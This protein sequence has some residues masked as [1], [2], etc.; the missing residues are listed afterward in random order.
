[1]N[2]KSL[3]QKL[4]PYSMRRKVKRYKRKV[5]NWIK[6]GNIEKTTLQDIEALLM[7]DLSISEGDN[8]IISSSFGSLNA[9]FSPK[10]LIELLQRIVGNKG[11][12]VMP[13]YPPGNSYE[14]AESGNIFDMQHTKSSM[15]VLT[16]V[17]SEMPEVY[18]SKHPTK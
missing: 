15:G 16:Q 18:K 8:L 17:F 11:N 5:S 6:K 14:W 1:M 9:D 3:V 10:E 4:L 12:I 7:N 2:I 13:F